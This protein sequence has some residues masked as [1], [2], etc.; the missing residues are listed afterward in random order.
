MWMEGNKGFVLIKN[1]FFFVT[2]SSQLPFA[3]IFFSLLT[4]SRHRRRE[5]RGNVVENGRLLCDTKTILVR[6]FH[7][8]ESG[9]S[10]EDF[11]SFAFESTVPN[12]RPTDHYLQFI[13]I[14]S[15]RVKRTQRFENDYTYVICICVIFISAETGNIFILYS[16][17]Q[18]S[19]N[20]I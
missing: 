15:I 2:V 8:V 17:R 1:V 7:S 4:T 9:V 11:I 20:E 5:F 19:I 10:L 16:V 18:F 14:Q 13:Y 6:A 3:A 12:S